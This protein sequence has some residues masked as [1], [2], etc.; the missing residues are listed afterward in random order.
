[1]RR[2]IVEWQHLVENDLTCQRCSSTEIN[3]TEA[4]KLLNKELIHKNITLKL[5]ETKLSCDDIKLSNRILIDGKAIE[6]I[7][8]LKVAY[9]YC[10]TC[11]TLIGHSTCC[12]T[13][14]YHENEYEEVPVVA[15]IEAINLYL[16]IRSNNAPS[17]YLNRF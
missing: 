14:L 6:D 11:S 5:V 10:Q 4:M 9:S 2:I 15:I 7:L 13:I 1:M 17:I 8:D 16:N 12:R 3:L